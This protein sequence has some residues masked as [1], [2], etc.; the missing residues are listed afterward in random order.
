[1]GRTFCRVKESDQEIPD[2]SDH[3]I[4]GKEI[5]IVLRQTTI[6]TQNHDEKVP[7]IRNC[8]EKS[9]NNLYCSGS[10]AMEP[11]LDHSEEEKFKLDRNANDKSDIGSYLRTK[12][13]KRGVKLSVNNDLWVLSNMMAKTQKNKNKIARIGKPEVVKMKLR[14]SMLHHFLSRNIRRYNLL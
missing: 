12:F 7:S 2:G 5:D 10:Y 4:F 13:R 11:P 14:R 1:M 6:A 8:N 9:N 3:N